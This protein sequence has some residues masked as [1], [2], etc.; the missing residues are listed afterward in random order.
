MIYSLFVSC[1]KGLEYLLEDE[2]KALGLTVTKVSPQGVYGQASLA[3]LYELCLWSR[4]ANR[5]QLIL[6]KGAAPH[7]DALYQLCRAFAWDKVFLCEKSLAIEFHGSSQAFSNSMFG[8]QVIK[9]GIVDYFQ[10]LTGK[11]PMID[12]KSPDIKL[13]AYLKNEEITISFDLTGYSL[14]QRG[15]RQEAGIAPLKENIAAAILIRAKW[16]E[17]YEEGY[18]LHDPFCGAGTIVIEA[19]QMAA[20]I[21]PGL[22]R[23]DQSFHHWVLHDETLWHDVRAKAIQQKRPL[24]LILQGSDANLQMINKARENAT[25]A[26]VQSLVLFNHH[27]LKECRHNTRV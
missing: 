24:S 23:H 3:I 16:P 21:A 6:L 1:P 27:A 10:E 18:A 25:L 4:L 22:I 9:D 12:R 26:G 7:S 5:V 11:R 15:Y 20:R 2:L 13:H 8:A 19:A 17:L 14:H